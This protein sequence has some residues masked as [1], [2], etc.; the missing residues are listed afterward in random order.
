MANIYDI[1]NEFTTLFNLM[2]DGCLDDDTLLD[3]FDT[4]MGDLT[5][6]LENCCKYIK[7]TE[8]SIE[9]L[10]EEEKRIKAKRQA[11]ENS[12]ARLKILMQTAL[13]KAG[14]R[15][16]PCGTFTVSVQANA[17]HLVLDEQYIENIPEKYLVQAEPTVNKKQMLEDLKSGATN[18]EGIAHIE[19]S[20]SIRI[21]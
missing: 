17:P 19:A 18:L 15:K 2:E 13:N 21:R 11:Q 16:L 6:K 5:A 14:E 9:G 20:E 7:N 1:A 12:V 8:A 10:K 4:A 3:A